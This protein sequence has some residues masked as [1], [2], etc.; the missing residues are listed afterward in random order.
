MIVEEPKENNNVAPVSTNNQDQVAG[1]EKVRLSNLFDDMRFFSPVSTAPTDTPT[2]P[3]DMM[4]VFQSGAISRI[5]FRLKDT[6]TWDYVSLHDSPDILTVPSGGTGAGS[7]TNGGVII[8]NGSSALQVTTAGTAGQIFTSNGTGNDPTFQDNEGYA[9]NANEATSGWFTSELKTPEG[10][11]SLYGWTISYTPTKF[12]NGSSFSANVAVTAIHSTGF[13][14]TFLGNTTNAAIDFSTARTIKTKFSASTPIPT[15]TTGGKNAFVGYAPSAAATSGDLTDT[16][17]VR[18]GFAFYDSSIYA[19][20]CNGTNLTSTFIQAY[21]G[22]LESFTLKLNGTTSAQFYV[23]GV[24]GATISTHIPSA[25]SK[26][27]I[28]VGGQDGGG[29]GCGFTFIS[30]FITSQKAS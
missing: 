17:T 4:R 15:G 27:K 22:T 3:L 2:R 6:N 26:V 5:Y 30:N 9:I 25:S 8:G 29:S 13:Y 11:A 10:T 18:V 23:N 16:A 20:S 28:M 7:F 21:S 1:E 12:A 24:L 19:I 14:D